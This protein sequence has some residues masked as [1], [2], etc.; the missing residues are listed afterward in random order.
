MAAIDLDNVN[1]DFIVY[2]GSSRS[3][4]KTLLNTSTSGAI[5]HDDQHRITVNALSGVSLRLDHGERL[6]LVGGNGAGKTTLLRVLAGV[7]EP[8]SGRIRSWGKVTPLFDI[9]LGLDWDATGYDNIRIRAIYLGVPAAEIERKLEDI[10]EFTELGEYLDLPVRTYSAGMTMRLA[11]ATATAFDAEILLMDEWIAVSDAYF[12][13]K[14]QRRAESFVERSSI[15]VVASHVEDVLTRLCTKA[16]WLDHG[17]IVAMGPV[18][19]VLAE[20]RASAGRS[21]FSDA[22]DERNGVARSPYRDLPPRTVRP[23]AALLNK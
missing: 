12:L 2:Q 10:A 8:T 6:G 5:R 13:E 18:N 4:K 17:H 21:V 3:L 20:Y 23:G 22:A 16:L 11:F 1:V 15:M 9:S 19:E 7:Y 14:A